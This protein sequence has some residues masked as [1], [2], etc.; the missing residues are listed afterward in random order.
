MTCFNKS[1]RPVAQIVKPGRLNQS[2]PMVAES[3]KPGVASEPSV[4][5]GKPQWAFTLVELLVVIAII[6]VIVAL[7]LPA[8]QAA[9]EAARRMSCSNNVK[10]IS[11]AAHQFES[12]YR[13]FPPGHLGPDPADIT[14]T[15]TNGGTQAYTGTLLFLLPQVEQAAAHDTV[16]GNFLNTEQLGGPIWFSDP[17]LVTLSRLKIPIF[18]CPSDIDTDTPPKV[19]SRSHMHYTPMPTPGDATHTHEARTLTDYA[20]G[21]SSYV[22]CAGKFG[23]LEPATRGVFCNRSRTR[24][25]NITDGTSNTMFFGETAAGPGQAYLW[26]AAGAI[27][28]SFGFGNGFELWGSYHA[29]DVIMISLADGSV[30][31]ITPSMDYPLFQ[32]LSMMADGAVATLD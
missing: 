25:A 23:A 24:F 19:I 18:Q 30:R 10:Q 1:V 22:G 31:T 26:I 7:L 20:G 16:A 21:I 14:L 28:T 8:V 9:R 17:A 11:L 4:P 2:P 29:G 13:V 27:S 32:N 6:G 12:S 5:G 3:R 15:I